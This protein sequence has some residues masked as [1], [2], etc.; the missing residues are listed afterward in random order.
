MTPEDLRLAREQL[1]LTVQEAA[2]VLDTDVTT[3]RKM[4]LPA[5]APS[6][7][8]APARVVRLYK[9]YLAGARPDDWPERVRAIEE[10]KRRNGR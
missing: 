9:L 3:I 5:D 2:A 8:T 10:F 1:R 4:E 6:A 7:R